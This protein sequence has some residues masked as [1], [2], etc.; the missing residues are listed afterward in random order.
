M[1]L[2]MG[3]MLPKTP[4]GNGWSSERRGEQFYG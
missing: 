3:S 4:R 2:G 1:M